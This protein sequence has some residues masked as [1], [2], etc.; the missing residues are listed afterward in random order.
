MPQKLS[1]TILF[2]LTLLFLGKGIWPGQTYYIRDI[3]YLFSPQRIYAAQVLQ[4]GEIPLWNHYSNWGMP[5]L[6]NWQSA[7]FSPGNLFFYFFSFATGLKLFLIF[8]FFLAGLGAYL[9]SRR[10]FSSLTSLAIGIV[11]L[12]GG[13]L[14][15][16]LEFL[17]S[18]A[19]YPWLFF[20]L[21][22]DRTFPLLGSISLAFF[23]GHQ[24][25]FYL[26]ALAFIFK[27]F[28]CIRQ[29]TF[30][31]LNRFFL[32]TFLAFFLV[33]IQLLP[34]LELFRNSARRQ[35][36]AIET[37]AA[38]SFNPAQLSGL[39]S[40][41]FPEWLGSEPERKIF[42]EKY[43]WAQTAYLGL[44]VLVFSI[45]GLWLAPSSV[46][47]LAIFLILSGVFLSLGQNSWL[48]QFLY[49]RLFFFK[50]FRYPGPLI[51]F[52]VVGLVVLF[53][54]GFEKLRNKKI[55]LF[56]TG[57]IILELLFYC[58]PAIQQTTTSDYFH[59]LPE[60]VKIIR[61]TTPAQ[62][63]ILSPKTEL[64]RKV[65]LKGEAPWQQIRNFLTGYIALPYRVFGVYSSGEPLIPSLSFSWIDQFYQLSPEKTIEQIEQTNIGIMIARW[66]ITQFFNIKKHLAGNAIIYQFANHHQ[67][68][69]LVNAGPVKYRLQDNKIFIDTG[70]KKSDRLIFYETRYPGW[71]LY[72][73][74]QKLSPQVGANIFQL[75]NTD[76]ILKNPTMYLLYEPRSFRLGMLITF[77][78][79]LILAGRSRQLIL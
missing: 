8:S 43:P 23:G 22:L 64:D 1:L 32:A 30:L 51:I 37:A 27:I 38:Q 74:G 33:A 61:Q 49:R 15:T 14:L 26:M 29:R 65:S 6:A 56:L 19:V 57:L 67:L 41:R 46:R 2:I 62:R 5:F 68:V 34:T 24:A 76:K 3:T 44:V 75:Y 39:I 55:K 78:T 50:L 13:F 7:I 59:Y 58:W 35:G 25:F 21:L 17:S 54:Y 4:K 45:C 10:F 70:G 40:P 18:T 52:T 47:Y 42:G 73:D 11:F 69:E 79:L 16:K 36:L 28:Y 12:G 31:Y 72:L 48:Y 60:T 9:F 20:L 66:P 63:F 53:G 77:L 71:Y